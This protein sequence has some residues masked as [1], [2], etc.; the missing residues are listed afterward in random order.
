MCSA[1]VCCAACNF[2]SFTVACAFSYSNFSFVYISFHKF[3]CRVRARLILR[4][5]FHSLSLSL[6]FSFVVVVVI[7][8][9]V[10]N[11]CHFSPINYSFIYLWFIRKTEWR[12][13]RRRKMQS[14]VNNTQQ[15]GRIYSHGTLPFSFN[16]HISLDISLHLCCEKI[17]VMGERTRKSERGCKS[18]SERASE[19]KSNGQEEKKNIIITDRK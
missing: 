8:I 6:S 16:V 12:L 11:F 5:G 3:Q 18:K 17:S 2:L 14:S 9:F 1:L 4:F 13:A 10:A 15:T 7:V 19:K